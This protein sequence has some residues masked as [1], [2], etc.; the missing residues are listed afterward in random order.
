MHQLSVTR[1][2]SAT[3]AT[4]IVACLSLVAL[5]S[6]QRGETEGLKETEKFVNAG[7][8]T[9]SAVSKARQQLQTT[10]AAYNAL[11]TPSTNLKSDFKK[12][13]NNAKETDQ[14][15]DAARERIAKMEAAGDTY[16]AGRGAAVKEIQD[17]DLS[18]KAQERLDENRKAYEGVRA[19][20]QEAGQSLQELRMDLNNQITYVGSDLTPG[21]MASLQPEAQKLNARGAQVLAKADQAILAANKYFDSLRPTKA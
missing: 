4:T 10:L 15:V 8:D 20:L 18:E 14:K 17:E 3:L 13:V 7:A 2:V 5:P 21:A 11:L 16:F 19:L 6:A 1:S 9:T 12:L